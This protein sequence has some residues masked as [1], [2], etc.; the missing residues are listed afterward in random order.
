MIWSTIESND[1]IIRLSNDS[2]NDLAGYEFSLERDCF[3]T[4]YTGSSSP[5]TRFRE[6]N[7]REQV[8]SDPVVLPPFR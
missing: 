5:G 1:Y 6:P 8:S 2:G 4:K 3:G 7:C